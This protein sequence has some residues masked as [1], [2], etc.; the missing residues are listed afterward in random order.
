MKTL[1]QF[2]IERRKALGLSQKEMAALVKNLDGKTLSATYLNYLEH[3]RGK[4]PDYLL[5]Q[6][7]AVLKVERDVFYF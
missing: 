4:P 1:G 5:D 2:L 7:A 6:F 3:D